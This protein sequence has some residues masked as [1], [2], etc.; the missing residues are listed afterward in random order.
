MI[1]RT[2]KYLNVIRQCGKTIDCP[3]AKAIMYTSRE[4]KY[5]EYIEPAYHFAS[6]QLLDLLMDDA[7][8]RGRLISVKHY[9]LLD[10]GDFIVQFMDMAEEELQKDIDDIMPSR[11]E[12]LL[13]LALRTSVVN[14]DKYKDDVRVELLPYDLLTQMFRILMIPPEVQNEYRN[15]D[16]MQLTGLEAFAFDYEVKW[17]L[18]LV[19]NGKALACYQILFRHLFYCKH[20][21]NILGRV[22]SLNKRAKSLPPSKV[23]V[24]ASAF[25]LRQRM[26]NFIQ[27]LDY[28]LTLEV[29]EPHWNDFFKKMSQVTNVDEVLLCHQDFLDNCVDDCMLT[30]PNLL[31]LLEMLMKLCADFSNFL[32][33]IM[34]CSMDISVMPD[35]MLFSMNEEPFA[36]VSSYPAALE[37]FQQQVETFQK[38]FDEGIISMLNILHN[39]HQKKQ[40]SRIINMSYRLDFNGFYEEMKLKS[41]ESD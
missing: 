30:N 2:G 38:K 12:S 40:T 39:V 11:L 31:Q 36:E 17:P 5:V 7:D 20:I 41:E 15:A 8:L 13:E 33:G 24:Y 28:Y 14:E 19:I 4:S 9:F 22:W 25:A 35:S 3:D 23:C 32:Q 37:N 10:Q 1:L 21:E 34:R 6:K 27:N 16:D 26:L 29:I 18:S